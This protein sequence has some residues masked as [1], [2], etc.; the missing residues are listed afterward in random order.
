MNT[1]AIQLLMRYEINAAIEK[2]EYIAPD[3]M[4]KRSV[5]EDL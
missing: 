4:T 3:S 2:N 1:I 5:G